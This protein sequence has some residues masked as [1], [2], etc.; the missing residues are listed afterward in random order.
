MPKTTLNDLQ[1]IIEERDA[2]IS[3]LESE[4][5]RFKKVFQS[6]KILVDMLSG[7]KNGV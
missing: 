2:K 6:L 7:E 3:A 1:K 4:L 5:N